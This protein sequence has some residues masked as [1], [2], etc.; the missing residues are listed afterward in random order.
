M[1]LMSNMQEKQ[2]VPDH[3]AA[4]SHSNLKQFGAG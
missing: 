3:Q 2:G 4:V 1:W